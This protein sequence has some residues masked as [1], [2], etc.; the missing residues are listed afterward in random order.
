VVYWAI[1]VAALVMLVSFPYIQA[2]QTSKIFRNYVF[3]I[4]AGLFF[5][6]LVGSL[7]FL[8]D[9]LRR[10]FMWIGSKVFPNTGAHFAD[11]GG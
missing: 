10:L 9:D 5:A 4:I 1:S 6:K 2:L 8:I 3:A 11:E 7:F